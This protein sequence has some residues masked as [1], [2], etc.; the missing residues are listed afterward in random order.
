[1]SRRSGWH[2]AGLEAL[3]ELVEA[4]RLLVHLQQVF[5]LEKLPEAHEVPA[6][7]GVRGELAITV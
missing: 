6:A 2:P 7:G 5:P 1:M 4:G 3:T